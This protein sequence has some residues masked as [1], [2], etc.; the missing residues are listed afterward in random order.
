[1]SEGPPT[2]FFIFILLCVVDGVVVAGVLLLLLLDDVSCRT[3]WKI[4]HKQSII[5]SRAKRLLDGW[6]VDD[7][8]FK[9]K[10]KKIGWLSC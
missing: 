8:C 4:K 7:V 1:M 2:F 10:M 5:K 9:I 6:C 3:Q